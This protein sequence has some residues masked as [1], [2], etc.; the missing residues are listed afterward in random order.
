MSSHLAIRLRVFTATLAAVAVSAASGEPAAAQG[1]GRLFAP[2]SV[3]NAALPP[4][5]PLDPSSD[6]RVGALRA[7][8]KREIVKG[9]GPW[10]SDHEYST[11]VY[12]VGRD[13][14]RVR[15][16]LHTG[17][18]GIPLSRAL[19]AGVPIPAHAVPARGT[20]GHLTIHQP[21]TD[22]LWEFWH[23]KKRAD[24][25]HADWGGALREV[26]S[27]PGHYTDRSWPGLTASEGWN[28]GSTATSLPVVAGT[29]MADELRR[30][31]IDHALAMGV[32]N[33][34]KTF[35]TWP[36]Q[37]R[38]GTSTAPDCMPEGAHLRLDPALDVDSLGLPAM[39]RMLALAAQRHG[40]VVRDITHRAV[41]FY[42][43]D[44][45]WTGTDPYR[46]PEGLFGGLRPWK[47]MPKFPWDRL[48]LLRMSPCTKGPCARRAA[49][50]RG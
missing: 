41:G 36:A 9:T 34:C 31:R 19:E 13:Q 7:E 3:W 4:S 10:L 46:G 38:D 2:D 33:A 20:D 15:V 47:F 49:A 23:A 11:P 42:A 5:A 6:A 27:S 39:T 1:S 12:V 45:V 40:V 18:W 35:F 22:T 32:P 24:G 48:Q 17:K 16:A 14:P 25:W 8:I 37:R 44:V 43:E 21:S 28:W 30:G 50:S 29:V 26:S